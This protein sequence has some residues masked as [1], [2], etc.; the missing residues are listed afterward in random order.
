MNAWKRL[1]E[2]LEDRENGAIEGEDLMELLSLLQEAW[3]EIEGADEE[4]TEAWKLSRAEDVTWQ[5]PELGFTLERHGATVLGSSRAQLHT[6]A[7]NIETKRAGHEVTGYRQ[8]RPRSKR[9][10]PE[11]D[12]SR[13]V[14]AVLRGQDDP[15]IRWGSGKQDFRVVGVGKLVPG[16]A[17]ET[18]TDRRR[19]F[20]VLMQERLKDAGWEMDNR[21]RARKSG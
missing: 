14:E 8:L 9:W 6:W 1:V 15:N 17:K 13:L 7:V 3:P 2:W 5:S 21:Y 16:T 4:K 20:R 12:V 10:D 18:I 11:P 19:R